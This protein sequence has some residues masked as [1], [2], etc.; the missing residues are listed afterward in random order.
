MRAVI[1][2]GGKGT[3]LKPYTTVIPKPLM[4]LDD[5][6]IL[7]VVL[8]QLEKA[9]FNKITIAVGHLSS[10]IMTFFENG[11]K[12]GLDIDYAI[13]NEPLGTAGPLSTITDLNNTFLVMNGDILTTLDYRHFIEFHKENGAIATIAMNKR[14]VKI[15]FGVIE[16][17]DNNIVLDYHEKPENFHYVSMG[18]YAFEPEIKSYIQQG[19]KLDFPELVK[20]L[21]SAGEKVMAYPSDD[22]WLDIG[23]WDD[24]EQAVTEFQT[25]RTRFI[26]DV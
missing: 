2:A 7:E 5:M 20:K 22:F 1:L 12:Y 13:E 10:L 18:I 17:S 6:P 19:K 21:L 9:G 11:E 4:P 16:H 14:N 26:Q 15:D 23:R 8:R 24:F 3:R 25:N